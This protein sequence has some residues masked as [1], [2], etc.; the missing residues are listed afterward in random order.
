MI[1]LLILEKCFLSFE[2][3]ISKKNFKRIKLIHFPFGFFSVSAFLK[4]TENLTFFLIRK[5]RLFCFVDWAYF[6]FLLFSCFVSV[7]LLLMPLSSCVINLFIL[8]LY[9]FSASISMKLYLLI[10]IIIIRIINVI[11]HQRQR[12]APKLQCPR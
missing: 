10:R 12:C 6:Y 3:K 5:R 11:K 4:V 2:I 8:E 1:S 9:L 7:W